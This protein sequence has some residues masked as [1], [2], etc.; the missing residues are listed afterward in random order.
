[1][2]VTLQCNFQQVDYLGSK[3]RNF[4]LGLFVGAVLATMFFYNQ[5]S[6]RE[7]LLQLQCDR[8]MIQLGDNYD[9]TR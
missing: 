5:T 2:V 3:M 8:L 7:Q 4:L 9:P 6:M 1:M